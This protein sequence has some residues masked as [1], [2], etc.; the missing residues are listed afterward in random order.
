[1]ENKGQLKE[2]IEKARKTKD[3]KTVFGEPI[4]QGDVLIVPVSNVKTVG[5]GGE[6][7]D[8]KEGKGKGYG[9]FSKADPIGYI[10]IKGNESHFIP[11]VDQGK[12]AAMGIALFGISFLSILR[13]FRKRKRKKAS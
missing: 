13:Y 9:F 5:G 3:N 1:M 7:P 11:I 4:K 2:L 12:I 8:S 10:E 6:M